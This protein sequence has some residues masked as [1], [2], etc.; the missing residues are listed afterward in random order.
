MHIS[1][2]CFNALIFV[3]LIVFNV[4][5][6]VTVICRLYYV[7]WIER[8]V[9]MIVLLVGHCF[10]RRLGRSVGHSSELLSNFGLIFTNVRWHFTAWAVELYVNYK[11]TLS[12]QKKS[13][14]FALGLLLCSWEVTT[15]V[16]RIPDQKCSL[17]NWRSGCKYWWGSMYTLSMYLFVSCSFVE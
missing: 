6:Y 14:R 11:R 1:L 15:Y 13:D 4:W 3:N 9:I 10:I 17:V 7:E 12:L 2:A 5:H 8:I 16:F